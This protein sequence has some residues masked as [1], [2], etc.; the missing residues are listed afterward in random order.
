MHHRPGALPDIRR[1]STL[2]GSMLPASILLSDWAQSV[3]GDM[4]TLS[5]L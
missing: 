4:L 5:N 2:D 1:V 3:T